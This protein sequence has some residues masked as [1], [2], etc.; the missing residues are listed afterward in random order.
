MAKLISAAVDGSKGKIMLV[1]KAYSA[2]EEEGEE[3]KEA[4]AANTLAEM[5]L[6]P[7]AAAKEPKFPRRSYYTPKSRS[8]WS[9]IVDERGRKRM[10]KGEE[11]GD[12][13]DDSNHST[14]SSAASCR[15]LNWPRLEVQE[16]MVLFP[17]FQDPAVQ[18]EKYLWANGQSYGTLYL[19][20]YTAQ[21]G[22]EHAETF[23]GWVRSMQEVDLQTTDMTEEQQKSMALAFSYPKGVIHH[24]SQTLELHKL[25][26]MITSACVYLEFQDLP[27]D[28][29]SR[30]IAFAICQRLVFSK[31]FRPW[32]ISYGS[33]IGD[34]DDQEGPWCYLMGCSRLAAASCLSIAIKYGQQFNAPMDEIWR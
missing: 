16:S 9:T 28:L 34:S 14:S 10:G 1:A 4:A 22:R 18:A 26:N 2:V 24:V 7:S 30:E 15:A 21:E 12:C 20:G 13:D 29:Q 32:K 17:C 5:Q 11:L 27:V 19:H 3:Q 33:C 6:K 23:A 31:E 8:S 25:S